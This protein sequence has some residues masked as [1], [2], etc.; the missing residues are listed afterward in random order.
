MDKYDEEFLEEHPEFKGKEIYNI[1][2]EDCECGFN[3]WV[4]PT[5]IDYRVD[6][7]EDEEHITH[8]YSTDEEFRYVVAM[9]YGGNPVDWVEYHLCP[10]CGKVVRIDNCNY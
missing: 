7:K 10:N 2:E 4:Y 1:E 9:E 3:N 8:I 6:D 5:H